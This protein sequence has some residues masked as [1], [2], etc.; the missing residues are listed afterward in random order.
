MNGKLETFF[1]RKEELKNWAIF[2]KK[3]MKR[4]LGA[5]I[6]N[7]PSFLRR[8]QTQTPKDNKLYV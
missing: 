1:D 6:R 3:S 5:E 7:Q 4:N 8:A 2:Y